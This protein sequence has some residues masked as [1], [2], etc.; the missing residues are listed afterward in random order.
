MRYRRNSEAIFQLAVQ[1]LQ[2]HPED[3]ENWKFLIRV[4][5]IKNAF[6]EATASSGEIWHL[7]A[8]NEELIFSPI[9]SMFRKP[10]RWTFASLRANNIPQMVS[11]QLV[12]NKNPLTM[13]LCS[14]GDYADCNICQQCE[15]CCDCN[16]TFEYRSNPDR[17]ESLAQQYAITRDPSDGLALANEYLI[18]N[19]FQSPRQARPVT[20][21]NVGIVNLEAKPMESDLQS[22]NYLNAMSWLDVNG[23]RVNYQGRPNARTYSWQSRYFS[24]VSFLINLEDDLDDLTPALLYPV[25]VE[26]RQLGYKLLVIN[27]V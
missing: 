3:P 13:I 25:I 8:T 10:L 14:C 22:A 5:R 26:A 21:L 7:S 16:N 11:F 18:R 19:Q 9:D 27:V 15:N 6:V 1:L 12:E 4:A 23:I 2:E 20:D 24:S 17:M